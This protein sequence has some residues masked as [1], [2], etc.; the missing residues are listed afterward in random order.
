M[1]AVLH[2]TIYMAFRAV[3]ERINQCQSQMIALSALNDR[4]GMPEI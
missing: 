4:I 3:A 2:E 1:H